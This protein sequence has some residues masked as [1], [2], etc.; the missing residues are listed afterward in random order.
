MIKEFEV[1][2]STFNGY[3]SIPITGKGIGVL[4]FHGW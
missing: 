2:E 1:N 4:E 3:L